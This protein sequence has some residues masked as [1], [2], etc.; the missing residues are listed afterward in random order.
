MN[1]HVMNYEE[2]RRAAEER[3]V[4]W[5]EFREKEKI[6]PLCFNGTDFVGLS[7]RDYLLLIECD[8]ESC[9][10]YNWN[11]RLWNNMPTSLQR[12]DAKWKENPYGED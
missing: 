12:K 5:E 11:Y 4:V 10:D 2:I 8:E 9:E 1:A 7:D 3:T 6:I